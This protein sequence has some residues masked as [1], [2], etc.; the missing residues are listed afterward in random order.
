MSLVLNAMRNVATMAE[1]SAERNSTLIF[2]LPM[3]LLRFLEGMSDAARTVAD[4]RT[5]GGR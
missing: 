1:V 5:E 4:G 2:P 3:E